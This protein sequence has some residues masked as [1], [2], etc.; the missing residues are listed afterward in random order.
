MSVAV[1]HLSA[2]ALTSQVRRAAA[3]APAVVR[4]CCD[5]AGA[6]PNCKEVVTAMGFA[7]TRKAMAPR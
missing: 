1:D 7:T 4:D 5:L 2:P 3:A 6:I